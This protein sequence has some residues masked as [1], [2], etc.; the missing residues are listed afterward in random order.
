MRSRV[1]PFQK[2]ARTLR[3]HR[4]LLL[5]WFRARSDFA[6]GATEGFNNKARITTRKAYGFR[7]FK[8]AEIALCHAIGNLPESDWLTHKFF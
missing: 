5:S 1:P 4:A 8:H 2:F 6:H 3:G 7:T